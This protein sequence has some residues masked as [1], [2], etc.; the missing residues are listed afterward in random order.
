M[1]EI[2]KGSPAS[3]NRC[4][5]KKCGAAFSGPAALDQADRA[6]DRALD[7]AAPAQAVLELAA[8]ELA[9]RSSGNCTS[10][11]NNSSGFVTKS[12][13]CAT[14]RGRIG[15]PETKSASLVDQ[16]LTYF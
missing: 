9:V 6:L 7:R 10:C 11:R 5:D 13:D 2:P 15:S 1:G 16:S 8:P 14:S 4:G 12:S 3:P